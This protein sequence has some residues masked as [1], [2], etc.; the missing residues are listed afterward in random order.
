MYFWKVYEMPA[1]DFD[2]DFAFRE[3]DFMRHIAR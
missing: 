1:G 2:L 3:I